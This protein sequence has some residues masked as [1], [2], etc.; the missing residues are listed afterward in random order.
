[1]TEK[2]ADHS[3][4]RKKFGLISLGFISILLTY[5]FITDLKSIRLKFN[6]DIFKRNIEK[7]DENQSQN[8]KYL[9]YILSIDF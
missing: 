5:Y 3:F 7:V 4:R 9:K 2:L 1:M 8:C 6:Y